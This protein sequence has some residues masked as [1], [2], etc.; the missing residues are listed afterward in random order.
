MF[1]FGKKNTIPEIQRVSDQLGIN[2]AKAQFVL[3]NQ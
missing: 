2:S 1:L 3:S